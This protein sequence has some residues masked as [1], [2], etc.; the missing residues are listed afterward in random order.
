[1]LVRKLRSIGHGKNAKIVPEYEINTGLIEAFNSVEKRSAIE[2]GQE[3]DRSDINLRG[4]VAAQAELL[5]RAF[6]LEELEIMDAKIEAAK[7]A[8][9]LIESPAVK[10][11]E[12]EPLSRETTR[13]GAGGSVIPPVSTERGVMDI[14]VP[15][16]MRNDSFAGV[17][18]V[19]L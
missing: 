5:R 9:K 10:G 17:L 18:A 1:V 8:P 2:T 19:Q 3:V 15:T 14:V 7:K 4:G 13:G 12:P 11:I 6:T 16:P